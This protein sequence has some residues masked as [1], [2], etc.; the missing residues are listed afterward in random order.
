MTHV[1]A[2]YP[3]TED[4]LGLLLD[5]QAAGV[6]I[7]EVQIPFSDPG[8][9]GPVIMKSN[10]IALENGMTIQG[11][12]DL[13]G[14][15]RVQGLRIPVYIMSYAN[16][17]MSFGEERFCKQAQHY[18]VSGLI[19]PDLPSDTVDYQELAR[20]CASYGLDLVPVISPGV[21]EER[22]NGY[23]LDSHKL[24]YLTSTQGITGKELA[25]KQELREL[26][27]VVRSKTGAQLALGF[28]IRNAHDV[29]QALELADLA[30]IGSAVIVELDQGG[31]TGVHRFLQTLV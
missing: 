5:M 14:Q 28:G 4:C 23:Q 8:A 15:A 7:I 29:K 2:G 3:T 10:D 17:V 20:Y 30:V 1:V 12:L 19:I 18:K 25:V 9:D 22:L 24:V 31:I 11:S 27:D 21:E 6:S 26:V 16:K 13:I